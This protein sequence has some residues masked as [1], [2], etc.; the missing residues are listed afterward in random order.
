MLASPCS[1][2]E[3]IALASDIAGR[4][5]LYPSLVCAVCEQESDWDPNAIRF[6]PAFFARYVAP[7][8]ARNEINVTEAHARA[9]SWGLM[10]VMGQT[11][12]EAGFD[13]ASLAALCMPE[14]GIEIGCRVLA[15]KLAFTEGDVARA[16]LIWNGGGNTDYPIQVLAR[17][18]RYRG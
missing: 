17:A 9:F 15:H 11:A 12:R 5:Q 6:E 7:Q 14:Q 4:H 8:F 2:E 10:Q 13:A 18:D 1:R 3:L 16:L